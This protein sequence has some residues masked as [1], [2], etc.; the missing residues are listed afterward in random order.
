M[1]TPSFGLT[2]T[3]RVLP[4]LALDFTTASL[5]SRVT[6]TRTTSASNPATY[7]NSSGYITAATN[8]QPR[9][10][11]DPIT[12]ACKGLLIEESRVNYLFPSEDISGFNYVNASYSVNQETAPDNTL[13]ADKLIL[14][15]GYMRVYVFNITSDASTVFSGFF[16]P[17]GVTQVRIEHIGSVG[18]AG[19]RVDFNLST[20]QVTAQSSI[21]SPGGSTGSA[22]IIPYPNG[23]YKLVVSADPAS[24]GNTYRQVFVYGLNYTP[25]GV[26]GVYTWG[27]QVELADFATSY[28]PTT[29]AALT[30][31][32]DVASMTGTNFSDWFN[33]SEGT[34]STLFTVDQLTNAYYSPCSLDDGTANNRIVQY[35]NNSA[36]QFRVVITAGGSQQFGV[37]HTV[38]STLGT[39]QSCIAYKALDFASDF[40]AGTVQQSGASGS[41]PTLT[42]MQIGIGAG[43][44]AINGYLKKIN[45]WPLRLT[46][47]QIQAYSK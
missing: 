8:N 38:T 25:D 28:I 33:A 10:D 26:I 32:A 9:F 29:S 27:L 11:Y 34:I 24:T 47:A 7:V 17:A 15:G 40:N 31:N 23:W 3:E 44:A 20:G 16:K 30:R 46:N 41:V 12:L 1:I 22:Q 43:A 39:N 42:Q 14:N 5:D 36:T 6:F 21:G 4:K 19:R 2:A 45:Y 35:R 37:N 18:S 13:T